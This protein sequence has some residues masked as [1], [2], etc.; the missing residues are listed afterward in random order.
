[1]P[2]LFCLCLCIICV[3]GSPK[4]YGGL[5]ALGDPWCWDSRAKGHIS[6]LSFS[7]V[8]FFSEVRIQRKH[9]EE[10]IED[11]SPRLLMLQSKYL[12]KVM[13]LFQITLNCE[14]NYQVVF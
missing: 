8:L 2:R 14:E 6:F 11:Y 3:P 12:R 1:M 7:A 9:T 10:R 5:G 13:L 4:F